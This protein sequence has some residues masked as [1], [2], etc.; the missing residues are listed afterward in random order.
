M[1]GTSVIRPPCDRLAL[2]V[3]YVAYVAYLCC[4][5]MFIYLFIKDRCDAGAISC[6]K[7][8]T[9]EQA[10]AAY[11]VGVQSVHRQRE[12]ALHL[13]PHDTSILS[14]SLLR[15]ASSMA[16]VSTHTINVTQ[17]QSHSH[18]V[19]QSHRPTRGIPASPVASPP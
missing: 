7:V 5:C 1:R 3:A 8:A 17:S 9:R 16:A 12:A 19:A 13:H 14:A 4:S 15:S 18:A 6:A 11:L 2:C 10:S